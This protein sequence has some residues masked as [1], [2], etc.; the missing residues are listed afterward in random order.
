MERS[1]IYRRAL[2]PIMSLIGVLGCAAAVTGYLLKLSSEAGF[3]WYW[4]GVAIVAVAGALVMVRRQAWKAA[5]PFWTP[6]TRR[7][8]AA[9]MP[10][11][12]LGA[13]LACLMA[14]RPW[15]GIHSSVFLPIIWIA[16][17][18]CALHAAG[19]F[20]PRG[21]RLLGWVFVLVGCALLIAYFNN[22]V[23]SDPKTDSVE[24]GHL[25]MGLTFGLLQLAYG[26]YLYFTEKG[27]NET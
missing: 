12:F 2:A 17:Y 1:A 6:P 20:M 23:L 5:E 21:I 14:T 9:T 7:V 8:T 24:L 18:G 22:K 11:F 3:V 26:I 13:L 16:L 27:R 15:E 19:F 25:L 10:P 4:T